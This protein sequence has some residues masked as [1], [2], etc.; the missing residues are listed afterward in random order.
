MLAQQLLNGLTLGGT[1]ALVALG[2]TLIFGVLE[3]VNLAHGE[4]FMAGALLGYFLVDRLHLPL[5]AA[6]AGAM[7]GA[8][9]LGA[10]LEFLAL[11]P[12]RRKGVDRLMALI[13]TIGLSIFLQNLALRLVGAEP[14]PFRTA[15]TEAPPLR[16]GPL[17]VSRAQLLVLA[18]SVALM[19]ALTWLLRR[20]RLGKGLRAVAEN[21][22]AAALLGVPVGRMVLA[23]VMLA[24]ALGGA[25]GVL[26]GLSFVSVRPDMGYTYGLKG[27]AVIILGGLGSVPGAVLGGLLMG[28]VETLT[29]AYG[30]SS[31]R[32]AVAFGFLF[33]MLLVRPS[34]I[35]GQAA[36]VARRS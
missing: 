31:W 17:V 3:I 24:S 4:V 26:V 5:A 36:G 2:Y 16:L 27:L 12:L 22:D 32:D 29:V 18:V 33:L 30:G 7:A 11:R 21:P 8:A 19:L 35:L 14:L 1:Y 23:A 15:L 20:T 13:S 6:L 28:L 25:A 10:A 34:G 9:L